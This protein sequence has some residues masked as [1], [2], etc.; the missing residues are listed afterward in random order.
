MSNPSSTFGNSGRDILRGP[1]FFNLDASLF[2]NFAIR[3]RI[4]MQFRAEALG[5]TNTPQFG[6]PG[7]TVGSST[8]GIISSSTGDRQVRLALKLSF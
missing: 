1:G 2:R 4:K 7:A 3:E 5:A 6:N 8:F